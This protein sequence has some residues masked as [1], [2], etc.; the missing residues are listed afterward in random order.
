M[1]IQ[2]GSESGS[3]WR[4]WDLHIHT[5][6]SFEWRGAKFDRKNPGSPANTALV[7]EMIN[8]LNEAEPAVFALMDYWTFDGWFALKRRLRES[9]APELTKTVFPGIE[10]R[11]AP[12]MKGRLNA[13]VLP[14]NE[15]DDQILKDFVSHL[16]LAENGRPLSDAAL[17][18]YARQAPSALLKHHGS[19]PEQVA[20]DD[21]QAYI[22]SAKIIELIC[23]SYREAIAKVPNDQA[24]PVR[25]KLRYKAF[26]YAEKD[27]AQPSVLLRRWRRWL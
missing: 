11:L 15:L 25:L 12:P 16:K 20:I 23:E 19:K 4:Q 8:A 27:V 1:V 10:L 22:A 6:A 18:D 21:E 2:S 7:D 14:S 3:E 24:M 17:I 26:S 13:Q 5:P 9:G